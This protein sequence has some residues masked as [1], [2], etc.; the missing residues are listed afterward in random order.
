MA[1]GDGPHNFKG[2]HNQVTKTTPELAPSP[3]FPITPTGGRLSFDIFNEHLQVFSGT[4]LELMTRW[5]VLFL[6]SFVQAIEGRGSLVLKV[7]V[8]WLACHEFESGTAEDSP[9]K[10]GRCTFNM[11]RLKRSP[12]SVE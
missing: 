2:N 6:S 3:N 10:G 7:T 9:C 5:P 12:V 4:R 1:F 8:S 11:P